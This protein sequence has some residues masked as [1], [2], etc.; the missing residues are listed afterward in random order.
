MNF[1]NMQWVE[2][3]MKRDPFIYDEYWQTLTPEQKERQVDFA[4]DVINKKWDYI[5]MKVSPLQ[6]DEFPRIFDAYIDDVDDQYDPL[7][8][9]NK[10]IPQPVR[11]AV[12]EI[13]KDS[14]QDEELRDLIH[15]QNKVGAS[16]VGVLGFSVGMQKPTTSN[17]EAESLLS[18]FDLFKYSL[19]VL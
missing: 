11:F 15:I 4:E 8:I 16:S 12:I 3:E 9:W 19:S 7:V 10:K 17:P 18:P 14:L 1:V 5:G 13:I 2:G 6:R